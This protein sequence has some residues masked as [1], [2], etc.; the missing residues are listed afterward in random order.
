M[1]TAM[2]AP[3]D[4]T[5]ARPH[6]TPGARARPARAPVARP[7]SPAPGTSMA[8]AGIGRI[9]LWHGGSLWI[10]R[11]AGSRGVHAHHAIRDTLPRDAPVG[12]RPS[13]KA[14]WQDYEGA[15]VG[16]RAGF[17]DSSHLSR[18][19]RRTFGF[20]PVAVVRA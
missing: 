16:H 5:P 4:T 6:T 11:A 8:V 15:I 2:H 9:Y 18:S 7:A 19:F 10:G 20:S 17:A 12:F 13:E 3:H 1:P 14:A